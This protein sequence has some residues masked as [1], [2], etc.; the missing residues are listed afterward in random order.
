MTETV[1]ASSIRRRLLWL[2][3]SALAATWTVTAA[4]TYVDAHREVD[5]LL[6]AHLR[7]AARLLV[8]QAEREL[9]ELD[10][11]DE[12]EVDDDYK[13]VVAFQVR[14]E[15]GRVLLRSAN[16][17]ERPLARGKRG[18]SEAR[19]ED[20]RWRVYT[21]TD[22]DRYTVVH[23]A[24]DH[25][26][27]D[28]IAQRIALSALAPIVVALPLLGVLIWWL[29]GRSLRPL[30]RLGEQ[31]ARRGPDDLGPVGAKAM[32]AE[33]KPLVQRLDELFARLRDTIDSE[34][35][36]TSHAAHE[37]RT[38]VAG[39]RAQAEVALGARDPVVRQAALERCIEAC[40][41][42]TR[43]VSQLLL[44]ARSDELGALPDALTCR[45]DAI[46]QDVLAELTPSATTLGRTLCLETTGHPAQ[47]RGNAT[48]L[49]ALLRN[50]VENALHHGSGEVRV[51]V[52]GDRHAVDVRVEDSGPGVPEGELSQLGRRF[53]R[54][55]E[56]RGS[57]SGLGLSIV[58]RIAALHGATL[59]FENVARGGFAV[60]VV[61][62]LLEG[63]SLT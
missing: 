48:L 4:L 54:A 62:P 29:V 18:F 28:R 9:D 32:P 21:A 56:A 13:T 45:V 22:D 30:D 41:R 61:L 15:N 1:R 17:P 6:D 38:P 26:T 27:R 7:Q 49:A 53:Y 10:L 52:H 11:D 42:M 3:L 39:L 24:E 47:V 36:F 5:A 63:A 37:L 33:L 2:L 50:L 19:I 12:H 20:V 60:T 57:G 14:R 40:D 46:A 44:L 59:R 55:P 51:A 58:S 23:V 34:R 31:I 35:R 8:A 43:L 25:A 16:A